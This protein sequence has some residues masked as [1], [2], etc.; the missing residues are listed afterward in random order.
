MQ[1]SK[2]NL[3]MAQ[4]NINSNLYQI[5]FPP[6]L[7]ISGLWVFLT[8]LTAMRWRMS[9]FSK[10]QMESLILMMSVQ[11]FAI[12]IFHLLL[13][14]TF[15]FSMVGYA[16]WEILTI[17]EPILRLYPA[18]HLTLMR[19]SRNKSFF[20]SILE[21]IKVVSIIDCHKYWFSGKLFKLLQ[22]L[23]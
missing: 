3:L 1:V 16:C 7:T 22:S 20:H 15:S 11:H 18:L 6:L 8:Q 10:L 23:N 2:N 14:A 17:Q 4:H 21:D 13:H 5:L 12:H 9:I 19:V